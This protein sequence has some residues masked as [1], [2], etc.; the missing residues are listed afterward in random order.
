MLSSS[1]ELLG[2]NLREA[3]KKLTLSLSKA[4]TDSMILLIGLSLYNIYFMLMIVHL[5]VGVLWNLVA[6]QT[7]LQE[8]LAY[9]YEEIK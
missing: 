5:C 7:P 8:Y 2:D 9:P 6:L 4:S 1:K 3:L